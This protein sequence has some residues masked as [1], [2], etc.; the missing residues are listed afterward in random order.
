MFK[1]IVGNKNYMTLDGFIQKLLIHA[2][3]HVFQLSVY[4][5]PIFGA[6]LILRANWLKTL[7][8]HIS[9]YGSLSLKFFYNG[10]FVTFQGVVDH[11][12]MQAHL[13]HI[14]K[15]VTTNSIVEV[16]SM[17]LMDPNAQSFPMLELLIDLAPEISSLLHTY[18]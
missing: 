4:L 14:H 11:V 3:E 17:Q 5:L 12:P 7:G 8:P 13:H 15:L 16:Y 18:V 2:H 9:N 1:V 6:D 10:K